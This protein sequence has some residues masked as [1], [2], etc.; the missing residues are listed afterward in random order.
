MD[1]VKIDKLTDEN[2][3]LHAEIDRLKADKK[4]LTNQVKQFKGQT[5]SFPTQL[6]ELLRLLKTS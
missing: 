1:K 4:E 2:R 6:S 5:T 3:I